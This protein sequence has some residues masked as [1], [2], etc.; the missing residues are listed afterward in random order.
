MADDFY[1]RYHGQVDFGD[2]F[3]PIRGIE[4]M[5]NELRETVRNM[6]RRPTPKRLILLWIWQRPTVNFC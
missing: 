6:R 3:P 5:A 4:D 1:N 2:W